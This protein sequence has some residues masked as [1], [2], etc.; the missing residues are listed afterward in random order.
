VPHRTKYVGKTDFCP[1]CGKK[2]G[3]VY[4]YDFMPKGL[5]T[6]KFYTY[7]IY[8]VY[9]KSYR[10]CTHMKTLPILIP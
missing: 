6:W 1:I 10:Y 5:G 9:T 4:R 7:G 8:H 2:R 3:Y